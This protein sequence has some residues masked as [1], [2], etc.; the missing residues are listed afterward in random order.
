M[1]KTFSRISLV[2]VILLAAAAC[3]QS[4][5]VP[6][7]SSEP[8]PGQE[9]TPAII[10]AENTA[11]LKSVY[12]AS[13]SN[14]FVLAK[15]T[16][17][18]TAVWIV[19]PESATLY[20]STSGEQ[21][22]QFAPGE[23]TTVYDVSPD[24]KTVAYTHDGLEIHLFDVSTQ[25]D[26]LSIVPDFDF[27]DAF[28]NTDGTLL[29]TPSLLD[30]KIILWDTASG[31]ETGSLS[32]FGTAAPVYSAKFGTDGKTLLW[33]SRGTVQPMDI[34]TQEMGPTLSHEDFV[35][36]MQV[37]PDGKVVVTTAAG[38]VGDEYQPV[39]TLWDAESGEIL[40]QNANPSYFSSI[41]F[42]PDS[43]L[44]AAGTETGVLLFTVPHGDEVFSFDNTE[45]INSIAFSPDG[46]KLIA[47]GNEGTINIYAVNE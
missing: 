31:A 42:S 41:A 13:V 3:Q 8:V 45:V 28:F 27:S 4:P 20:D 21:I 35:T 33:F 22:A 38:M 26:I 23:Y 17:D 37:S 1:K 11:A 46:V 30:I 7:E 18:S 40:R 6:A 9:Q 16:E 14:G 44:L 15:W 34:A 5:A 2:M 25:A 43:S 24:G 47:C 19:D 29:G 10:T 32:G 12:S 36:A 39:L